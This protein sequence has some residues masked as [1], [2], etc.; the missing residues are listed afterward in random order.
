MSV[1]RL[2]GQRRHVDSRGRSCASSI[3]ESALLGVRPLPQPCAGRVTSW[4][5]IVLDVTIEARLSSAD[6]IGSAVVVSPRARGLEAEKNVAGRP[7][8][9]SGM[10]VPHDQIARLW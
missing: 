4:A 1:R 9:D 10:P 7:D 8:D 5:R 3:L 6:P 2:W